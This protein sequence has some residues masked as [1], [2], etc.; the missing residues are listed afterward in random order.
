MSAGT[1]GWRPPPIFTTSGLTYALVVAL[2]AVLLVAA[3][4]AGL[5]GGSFILA[6][7][8][9]VVLTAWTLRS[10]RLEAGSWFG[11]RVVRRGLVVALLAACA[12]LTALPGTFPF[13]VAV[14]VL[15][16]VALGWATL[17]MASA[18]DA[19]VDERQEALR[20][21]SHRIAYW[22]FALAVGGTI[23]VA[24]VASPVSRSWVAGALT[25]GGG[26]I[27]FLELLFVLPGM[28]V[29]WLEPDHLP[30]ETAVP[31]LGGRARLALIMLAVAIAWP[32]L[33]SV[34]LVV[35]PVRTTSAVK[36]LDS[37]GPQTRC[38]ELMASSQ[39]GFGVEARVPVHAV[40][41]G[42]GRTAS[43]GWGL[44]RSDCEIASATF[45]TVTADQCSR[46]V[47]ADGTLHF[48]YGVTVRP[49]VLPFLS[50]EVTMQVVVDRNG[51]VVRFP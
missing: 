2:L 34:G 16:N 30:P 20:N 7:L 10:V 6:Y 17:R 49:S 45:A 50:R 15:L 27:A 47:G 35:L 48:T 19:A 3:S 46:T 11:L 18:P 22:T 5:G 25:S 42:D 8:A 21:R 38:V 39:V 29:A 32:A 12:V 1:S 24:Q 44:N 26:A 23:V 31:A 4:L 14:L 43:Q 37:V 40:A 41:C 51:R 9:F 33:L 36:P 28:V 13:T